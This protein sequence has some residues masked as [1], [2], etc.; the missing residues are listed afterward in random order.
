M[1]V[2]VKVEM[3]ESLVK[4]VMR[5]LAREYAKRMINGAINLTVRDLADDADYELDNDPCT[6]SERRDRFEKW[7]DEVMAESKIAKTLLKAE[8]EREGIKW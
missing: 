8:Y 6:W 2:L 7:A 4:G 5:R 3:T 1:S